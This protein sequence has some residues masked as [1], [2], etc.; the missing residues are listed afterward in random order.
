VAADDAAGTGTGNG[1]S[2]GSGILAGSAGETDS[3]AHRSHSS[4]TVADSGI[5][6]PHEAQWFKGVPLLG[7]SMHAAHTEGWR[8]RRKGRTSNRG[9]GGRSRKHKKVQGFNGIRASR[10]P[11]EA[12]ASDL[13]K[14]QPADNS[15]S[16]R[17]FLPGTASIRLASAFRKL[18]AP[19]DSPL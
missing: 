7:A 10:G 16:Q 3:S 15:V 11:P 17:Q 8:P 9:T 12:H 6:R 14:Q 19:V 4:Q 13:Q 2:V 18:P 5:S 1:G